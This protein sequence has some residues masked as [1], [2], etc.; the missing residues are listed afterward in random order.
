MSRLYNLLLAIILATLSVS[1]STAKQAGG[2]RSDITPFEY[3][4]ASA[5]T[6]IERYQAVLKAHTAALEAGVNV[7]YT[8]IDTIRLEL[9]SK[10]VQIPLTSDNDFKGCV[11]I[12]KNKAKHIYLFKFVQE[13]ETIDIDKKIIDD[14]DFK[15]IKE[16]KR[17]R[18]LLLVEDEKPWVQNRKGYAYGHTRKDILLIED[19]IA[20][21]KTVMPYN[22]DYSQ[23]KC[24]YIPLNNEPLTIKNITIIRDQECTYV[25]HIF[26]I[27]GCDD[28]RLSGVSIYTPENTLHGDHAISIENSTNVTFENVHI[29]GTYSQKD[30]FGYGIS[31]NNVWNFKATRLYGKGGW[32]VFGNNNVNTATIE[33]S[34]I[35]RFDVHCY[36]RDISFK[37]VEFFD[38]YNQYAS[39]YGTILYDKCT[40]T[41]FIPVLNGGS[42]NSF[43]GHEVIMTDCTMNA[44]PGKN[45]LF[46]FSRLNEGPNTRHELSRKCLPN[47]K[48]KG[49]NVNLKDGADVFYLFWSS[50]SGKSISG[51]EGI[52][53]IL[54]EEL[55]INQD[56]EKQFKELVLSNINIQSVRP[57]NCEIRD[58]KVNES[59]AKTKV[60]KG[61]Q[62]VRL[63]TNINVKG[64]RVRL[65]NANAL[66]Q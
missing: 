62:Q 32:G 4:L 36:G 31:L 23:P 34:K 49:L 44:S 53:E 7:D 25:T 22:N 17:N 10:A 27:S 56:S 58:V 5:K 54:I 48:I 55:T 50:A 45:V 11:F 28:V 40:F 51:L 43:V 13:S 59:S 60:T 15:N 30:T 20:Q 1:C 64:G 12:I 33:D 42:Y 57:I 16:L 3:G 9:P 19:G 63:K 14:G 29:E 35:N 66:K 65:N 21:N 39:V 18:S 46:K 37:N 41:D 8:G 6:G 2:Q 24:S 26:Q 61:I 47:V 52:S 38:L